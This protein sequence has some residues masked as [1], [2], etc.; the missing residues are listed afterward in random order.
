MQKVSTEAKE[1]AAMSVKNIRAAINQQLDGL[2]ANMAKEQEK[3]KEL[4]SAITIE[5]E[6]LENLYKLKTEAESLEALITTNRQAKE[7]LTNELKEQKAE[8]LEDIDAIKLK[9]KREQEEYEYK[10]KI[11]R[12]N[13]EDTYKQKK[14]KL[15]KELEDQKAAFDLEVETRAKTLADQENEFD[16]LQKE[17]EQFEKRLQDGIAE[18]EKSITKRLT[19]EWEYKQK[20][21]VKDLEAELKLREQAIESLQ[22]KVT[23]QQAFIDSL[24]SRTDNASQQVKDIALKA[25][26]NA[27]LRSLNLSSGDRGKEED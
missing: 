25:I 12:R 22:S 11:T 3:F 19:T 20:L 16:R 13:E 1:G 21:E 10:L 15:E 23:E 2:E 18:T 8:L 6:T 24:T 7:K 4:Q 14:A 26:E 17:A 27:G 9:W 5:K